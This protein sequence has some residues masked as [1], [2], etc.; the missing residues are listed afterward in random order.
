[1]LKLGR[2]ARGHFV[3]LIE[4]RV[5]LISVSYASDISQNFALHMQKQFE[6]NVWEKSN[7]AYSLS[8]RVQ[9]TKN[10]ISI[11]FF[12]TI[13]ST[14]KKMFFFQSASWKRHCVTY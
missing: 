8:I 5:H 13:I 1:M 6:K 7:D 4:I 12:F 14:S 10:Q 11:C 9:T 2:I 3:T